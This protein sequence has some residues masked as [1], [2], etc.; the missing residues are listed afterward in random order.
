MTK[1]ISPYSA[2]DEQ[3]L[4]T[5]L[6]DPAL[7]D[8][9]YKFVMFVFPWGKKG[10]PLEKFS[11]PRKWQELELKAIAAHIKEQKA[12]VELGLEPVVYKS[13]K[14]SGRGIGKSTFVAFL[15]LWMLSTRL[16]ATVI[17]TANTETQLKSRTW[18]ELGKWHT[19]SI[20]SHWFDK[21]ALS[22]KPAPW[23]E[24]LLKKQM[25]IDTG[26]YYAQAQLWSEENP[27]A[28]AGIHNYYGLALFF[29]EASGI[30]SPIWSVSDGFFTEPIVDRYWFCFSNPRRNT[31]EFYE[32]F[33]KYR[34][35]WRRENL[36]SRDVE[37]TDKAMLNEIVEKYGEDSDEARKEVK[38]QF[39]RQGDDQ[40]I[41]RSAIEDAAARE[42]ERDDYAALIMGVDPARFG[43][44]DACIRF[45]QGRNARDVPPSH[46]FKSI[47]NMALAN[48]C[49]EL[50]DLYNPD[51]V[52][53]DA[54]AGAGVIDRLR[55]RGY[56]VYEVAFGAAEELHP[57][58]KDVRTRMWANMRD[59]LPSACLPAHQDLLDDLAAPKYE[60][61]GSADQLKLE[62][63]EKMKSRGQASP[64]DGDALALTFY[65]KVARKDRQQIR[66][67]NNGQARMAR[68]LDYKVFG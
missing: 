60:F 42:L 29:D 14:A 59:W 50:I 52:C 53:I 9:P 61:V 46:K 30:P 1:T 11:G 43:N 63:K 65:V 6:W 18:A 62:S 35:Y 44:D 12:R 17:V 47:S 31:G 27:D 39:P 66:A 56:K 22:L 38:G 45:R 58:F 5:E 37:G 24:D 10:T 21:L 3:K 49:A 2:Q 8:D 13:A 7:A 23:F 55:E 26:Y 20:N 19:L 36:D 51:A 34:R 64:D 33:H 41:S 32:C 25:K 57:E 67:K 48:K 15:V 68:D 40:F 16:G 54:G 4:M 28:F